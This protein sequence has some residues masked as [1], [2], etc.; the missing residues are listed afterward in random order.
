MGWRVV[1]RAARFEFG[2]PNMSASE[3]A[4]LYERDF[5]TWTQRQAGALRR[6]GS[7]RVNTS[8]PVDWAHLADEVEDMGKARARE[9][10]SR[11]VVLLQ[12]LLKWQLQPEKRSSSWRGTI[13]EQRQEVDDLL[14]ENPGLKPHQ[15]SYLDW[16]YP[17]ARERAA[18][19]MEVPEADLPAQCPYRLD[20]VIGRDFWP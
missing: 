3:L 6:A 4:D 13:I 16:A 9:L 11:Y 7:E 19:D 10:R 5:Y 15:T 2:G 17:R 18:N 12:H 20:E 8:E 14:A 1:L